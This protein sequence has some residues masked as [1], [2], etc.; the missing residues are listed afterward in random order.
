[1]VVAK[2]I[3]RK[4]HLTWC[5]NKHYLCMM[6]IGSELLKNERTILYWQIIINE[7][8]TSSSIDFNYGMAVNNSYIKRLNHNDAWLVDNSDV[9]VDYLLRNSHN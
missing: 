7:L 1:M 5:M 3:E 2:V 9:Y 8:Q 4:W 6:A